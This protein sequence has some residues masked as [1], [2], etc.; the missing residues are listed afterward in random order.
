MIT[1]SS[2][3]TC[4]DNSS[5]SATLFQVV[6]T[7]DNRTLKFD[8]IGITTINGNV[9]I[10]LTLIAYGLSVLTKTLNPCDANLAG[11]C[12]MS[13][14]QLDLPGT[15]QVPQ[16][17]INSIPGIAYSIPDLDA[18]V[19][20]IINSSDTNE[21]LACVQATLSNGKTVD[22]AIVGWI[23]AVLVGL[24]IVASAVAHALG[25]STTSA[26]VAS[27]ALSLFGYYQS[28]ALIG[29]MTVPFPPIASA[30]TQN[31]Q[32][33]M[34]II[35]LGFMQTIFTWY[36]QA[37]GGSPSNILNQV[38]TTSVQVVKK[39]RDTAIGPL[40]ESGR[41]W[42]VRQAQH[43][44]RVL[45]HS[46]KLV[47]RTN[48]GNTLNEVTK[49][50]VLK[51]INRVAFRANMEITNLFLT[52]LTFF[53][54]FVVFTI[55]FFMMFKGFCEVAA[56]RGWV[57]GDRFGDFRRNWKVVLKG[58][59]YRI[60]LIA[61][62]QIATLC[63][64]ELVE[65]DSP[66]CIVLAVVMF[67][68]FLGLLLLAS[69]RVVRIAKSSLLQHKSAA[70]LLFSEPAHLNRWGF[71]YVQFRAT[72]YY[73]IIPFLFYFL[74]KA[75]L[76]AF[77]QSSGL[78]QA[79]GLTAVEVFYLATISWLRPF[80][81]KRTNAFNIAIS[82]I[83]LFNVILVMFFS[84]FNGVPPLVVGVMGVV[85]FIA[86]AVFALVLMILVGISTA[87]AIF[88]KNPDSRYHPMRDDRASFIK[89]SS[90][91]ALPT[92]LDAL[93]ATARGDMKAY[94]NYKPTRDLED[95]ISSHGSMKKLAMTQ[96]SQP[97]SSPADHT[98]SFFA[99]RPSQDSRRPSPFADGPTRTASPSRPQ[100][101]EP[102]HSQYGMQQRKFDV[103]NNDM[104]RRGVGYDN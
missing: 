93:G 4:M 15:L 47:A 94:H 85:F 12:P 63:L 39:K 42:L 96:Q 54:I 50:K 82:A 25:H 74:V 95:D 100:A 60:V 90:N 78:G 3:A 11:L 33:T 1:T 45:N 70:Y 84:N 6:F 9:S 97:L 102:Y 17:V 2:L 57:K 104:W 10:S 98:T 51:G 24:A 49:I 40:L 87:Y 62:T 29:M 68:I 23:T 41:E 38:S 59:M 73:F 43:T 5:L 77:G 19:T 56:K 86:N 37:T 64:W 55:I 35:Y 83:T 27:N 7:P 14:G 28:L 34:G 16:S 91:L 80:M 22:T 61:W 71:L 52:G 81:D 36:V 75:C 58:V 89:S 66:A 18:K 69:I 46:S 76:I 53:L 99:N 92:E 31:F 30:W 20:V 26:H 8:I 67:L 32:W 101:Y 44:V 88:S 21:Q 79:I 48:N 72:A 103:D 65:R 13:T